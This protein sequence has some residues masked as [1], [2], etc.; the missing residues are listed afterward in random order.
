VNE[1]RSLLLLA[2]LTG[3]AK[4]DAR[5]STASLP[6]PPAGIFFVATNGNDQ[7][8]GKLAAPN[9]ER[10]DGPFATLPRALSAA[11]ESK[12]RLV[13]AS[14]QPVAIL[15]RGG[16]YFLSQPL[17]LIPADSNLSLSA[18]RNEQPIIS[19][20]RRIVGWKELIV[21]GK[22]MWTADIPEVRT[23][24]WFFREL[25]VNGAR[26]VRARHP[27]KGYL[28][29]EGLLEVAPDWTHGH[30][31]FH[32]RPGD[33]KAWNTATQAEVVVMTRWVESRL[34]ILEV[35]EKTRVA[36]FGKR[37]VFE[38]AP[39]DLYYVEG[40]FELLDEPG[41]WYLDRPSGTLYYLPRPGETLKAMEAIAPMLT[42]VMRLE[43]HPDAAQYIERVAFKGFTFSHT[44]WN[45]PE[46]T[47][48]LRMPSGTN[49][50]IGGFGQAAV[51][52]PGALWGEGVRQ[53]LFERCDFSHLGNYA[54]ELSRGCSSNRLV[55]C[56]L[57]D[58]GAGGI[59]LGE[60]VIR[61]Q[62]QDQTRA[63][64]ITDCHIYDGGKMFASAV[65]IW[66]GQSPDN[67]VTHN[68]IHDFYYTG[69]SIGWTWGYGRSLAAGNLVEFNHVH[70]IGVKSGGD[71]PIL[72]DMGGIY[73]LGVQPG[74][75]I[76]NNVWH[77]LAA[78]RY[79]GWGIYFDEGSSGILAENNLVYRTTH[80]GF[81]QHYG[82]TNVLR[83]NIFAFGRDQQI[84]RTRRE[85]HVS[86]S[87]E[88]NLVYFDTGSLLTGDW[89]DDHYQMDWNLYFDA[90]PAPNRESFPLGAGS[91]KQWRE[92]GHD[93]H[94]LIADP[95]F[96]AP[97]QNDFRF[98]TN[99]PAHK[100]GFQTFDLDQVGPRRA[101]R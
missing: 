35:D 58:L 78:L 13:G 45:F 79:G 25:W 52:V 64:E 81:H 87:F 9:R 72:S 61:D 82:E 88:T 4:P 95:L 94:T 29:V 91:L 84:Q 16:S 99:S 43:G 30:S 44:E 8:S 76:R 22:R 101:K 50:E 17:S 71:G 90:R 18:Y 92:R 40:A 34:P 28:P 33:L 39:G 89:S 20:G 7:W 100:I 85:P 55:N 14:V 98:P 70:H 15:V 57:F 3:C 6:S 36:G 62:P 75:K 77:D 54:V 26:A 66:I 31:R 5:V 11:R 68:L 65:A 37:S 12:Q 10:T 42:Q 83:N 19:G 24:A 80:G 74:T 27:K 46:A 73:T 38:L 67:H 41:E 51:G 32:F 63:N 59:K 93:A 2:L 86:F 47:N 21:E 56:D 60:T 23:R 1:L 96:V 49:L 97:Q 48:Q 53:C 69:L